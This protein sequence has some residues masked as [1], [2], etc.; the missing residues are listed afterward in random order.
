MGEVD[1][2][3]LQCG[4]YRKGCKSI[5][6]DPKGSLNPTYYVVG[7][8]PSKSEDERGELFTGRGADILKSNLRSLG[9]D[10]KDVRFY[11]A[12]NCLPDDY[13]KADLYV[14]ACGH[15]VRNDIN[16]YK[17][18]SILVL[19]TDAVRAVFPGSYEQVYSMQRNRGMVV[20]FKMDDGTIIPA[21]CTIG[22]NLMIDSKWKDQSLEQAWFDD[23]G[24]I[25]DYKNY[26]VDSRL[27]PN[28]ILCKTFDKVKECFKRLLSENI[29]AF[30]FETTSLKPHEHPEY[31]SELYSVSFSFDDGSSYA[32]PL[33]NYWPTN[34]G[35]TILQSLGK[36]FIEACPDQIKIGHNTKFDLLWGLLK[37]S[38]IYKPEATIENLCP[39]GKYEDTSF[40]SWILDGRQGM[41]KLKVSAWRYF[42]VKDWSLD[43]TDVRRYPLD[44]I[45]TYNAHD[46]FYT[47]RLFQH[48]R[49]KISSSI[50]FDNLYEK[51]LKPAMFQFLKVEIN[52]VPVDREE[53]KK[54]HDE[55][56]NKIQKLV[57][58]IRIESGK[59]DL[60]PGSTK[61]L[62]DYF[63]KECKYKM[64]RKT[65]AGFSTDEDTLEYLIKTYNDKVAMKLLEY[66]TASKL[67]DTYIVGMK[68]H[69]FRDGNLHGSFNL[70]GTV[71][72]RTSANDP[73]MQNFPKRDH[74]E[75]RRIVK[76]P[77][78]YKLVSFDYGQIEARL[79]GVI[80]GDPDF[81]EILTKNY[82]IHLENSRI[83][84]GDKLAK[85]MRGPVKNGTF[86]MLYH[87]GNA[88][89]AAACGTTEDKVQELRELVFGK[90]KQFIPWQE[91]VI[92]IEHQSGVVESLFG[93]RRR[94]PIS[95]T[96][97]LNHPMQSTASDMLL[98]AMIYLGRRYQVAFTVHDDLSFFLPDDETL[99]S[100]IEYISSVMLTIPWV[101]MTKSP[102]KKAYVPLQVEA[103]VGDNWC[104][105]KEVL[106]VDAIQLGYSN[107]NDCINAAEVFM[108]E[109]SQV[110]W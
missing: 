85:E 74:K 19:G 83:L 78:G 45:L 33:F 49:P 75:I 103:S 62:Q 2:N 71:T 68:K 60:N 53:L 69:I 91:E 73:N 31:Q 34:I 90:F 29:V 18:K 102:L 52:G 4:L 87:G 26:K 84:F 67:Q 66:R 79:F 92:K 99:E 30:D 81:C 109:L 7:E 54:L 40:L 51:L 76:A 24:R 65:A 72:G 28:I 1:N 9:I 14:Q 48:L 94:S 101:F 104:D 47:L 20:P 6:M 46:S 89:V 56:E 98:S 32:I 10:L 16:K 3:C 58:E 44:D 77:E 86:A 61:Q 21:V 11:N 70:T 5:N 37:A 17:P 42:G 59:H 97:L 63:V 22:Q 96:E 100:N 25:L 12:I 57:Q 55:Y 39:V 41:S 95:V 13:T 80:T 106:K 110:G 88:T 50:M 27:V 15:R 105:Q 38:K 43:V 23:L 108:K 82:D 93:R 8:S 107:E 35:L 36:W 64:P